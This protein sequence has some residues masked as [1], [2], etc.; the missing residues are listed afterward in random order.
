MNQLIYIFM[1]LFFTFSC[2]ALKKGEEATPTQQ[3]QNAE[4][5]IQEIE[6]DNLGGNW[7]R[8]I[9]LNGNE[10][11]RW[12]VEKQCE[13]ESAPWRNV[14]IT[15]NEGRYTDYDIK[16]KCRYRIGGG[17]IR[18][19]WLAPKSD[20]LLTGELTKDTTIHATRIIVMAEETFFLKT[21][22]L[23]LESE[24][25]LVNGTIRAFP[26]TSSG[27]A[28]NAGKLIVMAHDISVPGQ[29]AL[30]GM[31]GE[32]GKKG[33]N[34]DRPGRR[35]GRGGQ[36]KNGGQGGIIEF[37]YNDLSLHQD[38][39]SVLGG[40]AGPGGKGGNG[41]PSDRRRECDVVEN[42][43]ACHYVTIPQGDRGRRG[44]KG[45]AGLEGT[46]VR[47]QLNL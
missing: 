36:G 22:Q 41:G 37:Y 43:S 30:D 5:D 17:I 23:N 20:Y 38:S 7:S 8:I 15:N 25:F 6:P 4:Y 32:E 13:V 21:F 12:S 39:L 40:K 14:G 29:I 33:R 18:T 31:N 45:S 35:G 11:D 1:T 47:E 27:S 44:E 2:G 26:E 16:E 46:I 24:S 34:E 9:Q 10:I 19:N 3:L 28:V 42:H